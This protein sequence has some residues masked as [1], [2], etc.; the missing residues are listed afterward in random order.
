M[1]TLLLAVLTF[2]YFGPLAALA[3]T[4][5]WMLFEHF[6]VR[7]VTIYLLFKVKSN[8][9]TEVSPMQEMLLVAGNIPRISE[10][11]NANASI[12]CMPIDLLQILPSEPT[13]LIE[14]VSDKMRHL[15]VKLFKAHIVMKIF[16]KK[17]FYAFLPIVIAEKALAIT[18]RK[19]GVEDYTSQLEFVRKL[20]ELTYAAHEVVEGK[21]T[22]AE[23]DASAGKVNE[24]ILKFSQKNGC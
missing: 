22:D 11:F 9:K 4:I 18:F 13:K 10:S 5:A 21:A 1:L 8:P 24:I 6:A 23:I 12:V 3:A 20:N 14:D 19:S 15:A 2:Y 7:T 17:T 16:N